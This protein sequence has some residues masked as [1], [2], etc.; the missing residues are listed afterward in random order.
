MHSMKKSRL[1]SEY[2]HHLYWV[3][4]LIRHYLTTGRKYALIKKYALIN[5]T[6]QYIK[7]PCTKYCDDSSTSYVII[8]GDIS[9]PPE[10][11]VSVS[12]PLTTKGKQQNR[13]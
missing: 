11:H 2:Y 8:L 1:S 7:S 3:H 5:Q 10:H 4:A 12:Q 6:L 13:Q 9:L